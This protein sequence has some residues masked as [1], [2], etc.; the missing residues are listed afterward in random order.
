MTD[1]ADEITAPFVG[2]L[3]DDLLD[4]LPRHRRRRR[5]RRQVG[6]GAVA[7]AVVAVVVLVTGP[8][9]PGGGERDDRGADV[10]T[11]STVPGTTETTEPPGMAPSPEPALAVVQEFLDDLRRGD[12]EAAAGR[13]TGYP[14]AVGDDLATR[15]AGVEQMLDQLPWLADPAYLDRSLEAPIWPGGHQVVT[16]TASTGSD[17]PRKA[18]AF[19]V[20]RGTGG[21]GAIIERLPFPGPTSTPAAGTAIARGQEIV[22][23]MTLVEAVDVVAWF[24]GVEVPVTVT[25]EV[26]EQTVTVHV[27]DTVIGQ[28]VLTILTSTPDLQVAY[29][30]WFPVAD[31]S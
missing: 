10:A 15:V 24:G 14:N 1:R 25:N 17:Q 9:G 21:V 30:F 29:A 16:V 7:A 23:P 26:E 31:G 5:R 3:R 2:R 20:D 19:V 13:W 22:V 12:L 6:L 4:N 18:A 28:T 11:E 8:G 27:P